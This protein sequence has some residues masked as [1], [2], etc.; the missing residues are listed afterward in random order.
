[1]KTLRL[2]TEVFF[3]GVPV[4]Y[5]TVV[6]ELVIYTLLKIVSYVFRYLLPLN[7]SVDVSIL[8]AGGAAIR[9]WAAA[10]LDR[11]LFADALPLADQPALGEWTIQVT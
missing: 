4:S 8:D 2:S 11:G 3:H 10:P 1:M 5:C 9:E 7:T 6:L